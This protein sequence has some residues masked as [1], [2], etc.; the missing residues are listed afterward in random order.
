MWL[1]FL[2]GS[3]VLEIKII[4]AIHIYTQYNCHV[5]ITGVKIAKWD[6]TQEQTSTLEPNL[7]NTIWYINNNNLHLTLIDNNNNNDENYKEWM[8]MIVM[9]IFEP[10]ISWYLVCL[11][12]CTQHIDRNNGLFMD[13]LIAPKWLTTCFMLDWWWN[14]SICKL[15]R[16]VIEKTCL[17][18]W[19]VMCKC[20]L[21]M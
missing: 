5:D 15:S 17:I 18:V 1:T 13:H 4:P 16:I 21:T 9:R 10:A 19:K 8:I 11:I 2:T 6:I 3:F 12:S 20:S 14:N 7:K